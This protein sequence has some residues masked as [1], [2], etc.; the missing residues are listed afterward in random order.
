MIPTPISLSLSSL[1]YL[2][3][4]FY[5]VTCQNQLLQCPAMFQH[6]LGEVGEP[7]VR[8]VPV[9][10]ASGLNRLTLAACSK[11]SEQTHVGNLETSCFVGGSDQH[12]RREAVTLFLPL[13][14]PEPLQLVEVLLEK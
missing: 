7:E 2:W 3:D 1:T 12:Y 8:A 6:F 9:V 11:T 4:V 14:V 13:T 5:V 10:H